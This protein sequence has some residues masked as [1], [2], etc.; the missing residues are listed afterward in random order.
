MLDLASDYAVNL[1]AKKAIELLDTYGTR[2]NTEALRLSQAYAGYY[3]TAGD[4]DRARS[5]YDTIARDQ[6]AP[7]EARADARFWHAYTLYQQQRYDEAAR[8]FQALIDSYGAEPP[9]AVR[10]SVGGARNYLQKC[11]E[12]N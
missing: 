6:T 4:P 1:G 7:E 8:G 10:N 2:T 5:L 3:S 12:R 9:A 11:R